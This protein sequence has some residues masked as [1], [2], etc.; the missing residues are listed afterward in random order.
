MAATIS[1]NRLNTLRYEVAFG[2]MATAKVAYSIT[3]VSLFSGIKR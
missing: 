1:K 2:V 3:L